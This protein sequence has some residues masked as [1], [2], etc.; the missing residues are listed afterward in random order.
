[1]VLKKKDLERTAYGKSYWKDLIYFYFKEE[2]QCPREGCIE[3]IGNNLTRAHQYSCFVIVYLVKSIA[4]HPTIE[5]RCKSMLDSTARTV[6]I[7]NFSP[8]P[9]SLMFL[10]LSQR[11][12]LQDK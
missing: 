10:L 5:F 9:L 6:I 11:V 12:P 4:Y 2:F 8:L 7:M 1:M 3:G